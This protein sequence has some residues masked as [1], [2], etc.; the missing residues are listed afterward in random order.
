MS[1]EGAE[2]SDIH[3]DKIE[4]LGIEIE[5]KLTSTSVE[6]LESGN[7][8]YRQVVYIYKPLPSFHG[9]L[10]LDNSFLWKPPAKCFIDIAR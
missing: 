6:F 3:I 2:W 4:R 5:R 7:A 1:A 8:L 10:I 9:E